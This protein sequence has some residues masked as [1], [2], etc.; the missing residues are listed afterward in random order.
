[1]FEGYSKTW[2]NGALPAM[3]PNLGIFFYGNGAYPS[4]EYDTNIGRQYYPA[5][6]VISFVQWQ[7]IIDYYTALSPDSLMPAAQQPLIELN[8]KLF[9]PVQASFL[10]KIPATTF[11][12]IG[13]GK[14]LI[15]CDAAAKKMFVF[16]DSLQLAD[17]IDIPGPITDVI[18]NDTAYV[19]C[20]IGILSPNNGKTGSISSIA[21]NSKNTGNTVFDSLMRPVH[22]NEADL[23]KDGKPDLIVCE[24]GNLKGKLS[25]LE[26]KSGNKYIYHIIRAQPGAVKTYITDDNHD[27]L[28]DIWALFAQADEGIFLFTNKGNGN[29]ETK[30]I[31]QFPPSYGSSSFELNDFNNDGFPDIIY[32]CGDNADYSPVLKPYHGVYIY[33]NDGSNNF[34]QK[35]F[36]S[37]NGCYKAMARD[38]DKDGDLDIAAIAFFADYANHPE[39]GFV[40]LKNEGNYNFKPYSLDAAKYGRWLT[41]DAGDLDGDGKADLVLGNFSVVPSISKSKVDWTK[42]PPYLVL[43]NIQ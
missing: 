27:G 41:M 33:L 34:T 21:Y 38:F 16:N 13:V 11:I 30:R 29:F 43:R 2:E 31:L 7:H 42:Q 12:K 18:K 39:E 4:N 17:S 6:Q 20:N 22:I 28:P 24:F 15:T 19:V 9:T 40:Y 1:L 23:N 3:G 8:D 5:Q 14:E 10:Y 37:I 35:Y 25:W 36:Y 26:N 32:T